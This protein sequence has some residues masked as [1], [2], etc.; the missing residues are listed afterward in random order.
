MVLV[1]ICITCPPKLHAMVDICGNLDIIGYLDFD[2]ISNKRSL[3]DTGS[4][5][6]LCITFHLHYISFALHLKNLPGQHEMHAT[7]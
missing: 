5:P 4:F 3:S 1:K 7:S 6:E 2:W